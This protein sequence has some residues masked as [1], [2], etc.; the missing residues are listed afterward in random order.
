ME[1]GRILAVTVSPERVFCS[2]TCILGEI[3][4]EDRRTRPFSRVSWKSGFSLPDSRFTSA[5]RAAPPHLIR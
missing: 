3:H 5:F 2:H 4:L 1:K